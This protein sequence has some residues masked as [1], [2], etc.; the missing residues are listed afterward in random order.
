MC[1]SC[2]AINLAKHY[3]C[4][5]NK[6]L[7]YHALC[8]SHLQYGLSV[9]G[10]M[11]SKKDLRRLQVLQNKNLRNVFNIGPRESVKPKMK[12][13]QLLN[14]EQQI[15]LEQLKFMHRIVNGNI[16]K[17]ILN[18]MRMHSNNVTHTYNTRQNM[19]I[20]MPIHKTKI[21]STSIIAR[22]PS[23]WLQLPAKLKTIANIKTFAT[24][25]KKHLLN[26]TV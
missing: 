2:Y 6:L 20:Q 19:G 18:K 26:T 25:L 7:L 12:E 9:W 22:G 3:V 17:R 24:H 5:E 4:T 13:Y 10:Q 11:I 15:K 14:V 8:M 16:S 1:C 23:L 21:F